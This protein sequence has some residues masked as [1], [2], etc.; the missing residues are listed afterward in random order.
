MK[1]PRTEILHITPAKA[2]E[3]L[4]KN[5]TNRT[6]HR[7]VVDNYKTLLQRG[8]YKLTHQGIAFL[9][10]GNLGDGQH[11][12]TAISEMPE[13]FS[14]QMM[15]TFDLENDAFL[16]LD[17]GLRRSH[18]D[19]LSI[20]A[21][22]AAVARYLAIIHET[23]R[24][25]VT[26]QSLI[27]F[28]S[29]TERDYTTLTNFCPR[30]TKTWASSAVRSAAIIQML[31]GQ[32]DDYVCLTYHALNH[33]DFDAMPP[34][35]QALFRQHT[36]GKIGRGLD[37]YCRAF[38]VFDQRKQRL[39]TIQISDTSTIIAKTRDLIK[40]HILG[41]MSLTQMKKAPTSGAKRVQGKSTADL[42]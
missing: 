29:G 5:L 36:K 31:N 11:R 33:L 13:T 22:L 1:L 24:S 32:D 30:V 40:E 6:I 27:P 23:S 12:L 17:Q 15:V 4:K 28:V 16:A 3:M 26:T 20:P 18:A 9:R 25:S 14:V 2:R 42:Y 37:M 41:T 7:A 21:G 38:N 8:E 34:I 35:A 19:L 10:N 39:T